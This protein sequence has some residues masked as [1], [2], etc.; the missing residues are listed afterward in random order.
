MSQPLPHKPHA[1]LLDNMD[2][3]TLRKAVA[4]IGGACKAEAG[5]RSEGDESSGGRGGRAN[6]E[7][8]RLRPERPVQRIILLRI[9]LDEA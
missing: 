1:V 5:K 9:V 4:R 8:H 6:E 2:T 7:L 3:T